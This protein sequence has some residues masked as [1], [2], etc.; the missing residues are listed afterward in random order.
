MVQR[1]MVLWRNEG[2]KEREE[3]HEKMRGFI[4]GVKVSEARLNEWPQSALCE[5]SAMSRG[6]G[7][8]CLE[9]AIHPIP[10]ESGDSHRVQE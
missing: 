9:L 5:S 7:R 10:A 6:C 3:R 8:G 4:V 1:M 2:K